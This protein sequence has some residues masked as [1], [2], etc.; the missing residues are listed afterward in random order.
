MVEA[1]ARN[2]SLATSYVHIAS[3]T[4]AQ[5]KG[6]SFLLDISLR[7][8]CLR[9]IVGPYPSRPSHAY[10]TSTTNRHCWIGS[11]FTEATT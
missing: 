8:L 1:I 11:I 6:I 7:L 5:A 2:A 10:R 4:Q 9:I 3:L